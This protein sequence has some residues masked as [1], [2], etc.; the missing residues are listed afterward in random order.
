M[1]YGS[2]FKCHVGFGCWHPTRITMHRAGILLV[3]ISYMYT[4]GWHAPDWIVLLTSCHCHQPKK[5]CT[6]HCSLY[7]FKW[8][9]TVLWVTIYDNSNDRTLVTDRH[10]HN[11]DA[12]NYSSGRYTGLTSQPHTW[13]T[14]L[15]REAQG[16]LD[17]RQ[18]CGPSVCARVAAGPVCC[19]HPLTEISAICSYM[20][21]LP[22]WSIFMY[23]YACN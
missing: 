13:R 22:T 1:C 9:H 7:A 4:G 6:W 14:Q 16:L 19:Y 11:H 15:D 12:D 20:Y 17:D 10:T 2:S 18:A 23:M 3:W 5:P 8:R 21:I